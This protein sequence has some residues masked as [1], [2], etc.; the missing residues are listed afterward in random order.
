[1]VGEN[2]RVDVSAD[3]K[4]FQYTDVDY[5]TPG[6]QSVVGVDVA[7]D[8]ISNVDNPPIT[9]ETKF[10]GSGS[11]IAID[12]AHILTNAH[13]VFD[14]GDR[15]DSTIAPVGRIDH[16]SSIAGLDTRVFNAKDTNFSSDGVF[17]LLN[18]EG[19]LSDLSYDPC[20]GYPVA[21]QERDVA[22]V[23]LSDG[24]TLDPIN[25]IGIAAFLHPE[26]ALSYITEIETGGFPAGLK[27]D[28]SRWEVEELSKSDVNTYEYC[29]NDS[30]SRSGVIPYGEKGKTILEIYNN[31]RFQHNL[32]PESGQS[33]SGI[34][35]YFFGNTEPHLIGVHHSGH[36]LGAK[37][38]GQ[39]IT[40]DLYKDIINL[41]AKNAKIEVS[42]F[43]KKLPE[44]LL[45]G[46]LWD[47][48]LISG[49]FRR[50][51]IL[52]LGGDDILRGAGG[53]DRLSGGGGIDEAVYSEAVSNYTILPFA[54][55]VPGRETFE[56]RVNHI[57][58]SSGDG[59]DK[60]SG[61]E[62]TTFP[63]PKVD[64]AGNLIQSREFKVPL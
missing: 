27:A 61:I 36:S 31:G 39:A 62:F 55:G 53:D 12:D 23:R 21:L 5:D 49:T 6:F 48:D 20:S 41:T 37:G 45:I 52:G 63:D 54:V 4:R 56:F 3:D 10:A 47:S 24:E 40:Y 64:D 8:V 2:F 46:G 16:V 58:G 19:A 11:G 13:V 38:I 44:N 18:F 1:M 14:V 60:L 32:Y 28:S 42:L 51:Q 33:G 26:Q 15:Y 34:W 35:S 57:G 50:E 29:G 25:P 9:V 59:L 22:L 43:A 17:D 7:H 30:F